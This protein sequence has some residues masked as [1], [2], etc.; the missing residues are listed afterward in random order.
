M[1][2]SAL[3]GLAHHLL[4]SRSTS[5]Y[6]AP[7][8]YF[9]SLLLHLFL[10][11]SMP[12]MGVLRVSALLT[13]LTLLAL[14]SVSTL[15]ILAQVVVFLAKKKE[16]YLSQQLMVF[17]FVL[18]PLLTLTLMQAATSKQL[19]VP[20]AIMLLLITKALSSVLSRSV[21]Y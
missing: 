2:K 8:L 6:F 21:L 7:A 3:F 11:L 18:A 16:A 14:S 13:G 9:L 12:L 1:V 19:P 5:P 20:L 10:Y 15:L 17:R 4:Q